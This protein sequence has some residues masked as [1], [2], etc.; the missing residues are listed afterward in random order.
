MVTG[1][2]C[3]APIVSFLDG[4]KRFG[5]LQSLL[6]QVIRQRSAHDAIIRSIDDCTA[7][8]A[9]MSPP[10]MAAACSEA[11]RRQMFWLPMHCPLILK[12]YTALGISQA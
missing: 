6:R 1:T 7:S 10:A 4:I 2:P 12:G 5:T 9:V 8:V 11:F 3:S